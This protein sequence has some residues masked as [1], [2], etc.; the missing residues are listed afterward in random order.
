V[1]DLTD[2]A[3]IEEVV[4]AGPVD[5]IVHA[6]ATAGPDLDA[7]RVVNRDGTRAVVDAALAAG[8]GR[9]VHVSTT[10]STTSTPSATSRWRRTPRWSSPPRPVG[11][12]RPTP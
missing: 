10:A 11:T 6:A 2:A 7:V 3:A 1:V 12:S 5:G 9:V 8:V 4:A